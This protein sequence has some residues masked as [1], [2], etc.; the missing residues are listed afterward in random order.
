MDITRK[1]KESSVFLGLE[2]GRLVP[3]A[4]AGAVA[5]V[6]SALTNALSVNKSGLYNK[7]LC[8]AETTV[9]DFER[10]CE[11]GG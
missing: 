10:G 1:L 7:Y 3:A 6:S 9:M 11:I 8:L 2:P 4:L 5:V